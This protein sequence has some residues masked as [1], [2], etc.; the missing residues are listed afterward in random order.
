MFAINQINL[1]EIGVYGFDYDYTLAHY[2]DEMQDFI[3]DKAT[4]I[5][6]RKFHFPDKL[7]EYK[8]TPGFCIRG[9]HYDIQRSLL[10]KIDACHVIQLSTVYKGLR[11]LS[12]EETVREFKG[13]R[14]IPKHIMDESLFGGTSLRQLMDIF[15]MPEMMLLT[16]VVEYFTQNNIHY[17]PQILFESVQAAVREVHVEGHLHKEVAAN[18]DKYL[19]KDSLC[20]LIQHLESSNKTIFLITNSALSFVDV[21]MRHLLGKDWRDAFDV[22]IVEAR[23]PGFFQK[24]KRPFK[25]ILESSHSHNGSGGQHKVSWERVTE[26]EKGDV[27]YGGCI[28][29]LM[30][31]SGWKGNEVIYFGD[32]IYTDLTDPT[33]AYGWRTGA[34]IPELE[35]EVRVM[36]SETF[37]RSVIW[38]QTLEKLLE[39]M[40]VYRDAESRMLIKDWLVERDRFKRHIKE[41]FNERFGSVFRANLQASYFSSRLCRIADIYTSSVNNLAYYHADHF[42]FPF[43]GTL[44]HEIVISLAYLHDGFDLAIERAL[45]NRKSIS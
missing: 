24:T 2:S 16:N 4:E 39:R 34:V 5:L 35:H 44:P 38:V 21:G 41:I 25:K 40:Q 37:G 32:Q 6:H 11:Q 29:D 13:T 31:I 26:F 42:F 22:I 28:K 45:Q 8:Y 19:T 3:Y 30:E 12:E 27:Y 9:L 23:K 43:R 15:S 18:V 20:N 14:H 1:G 10:M 36:N 7:L 33:F 17:D